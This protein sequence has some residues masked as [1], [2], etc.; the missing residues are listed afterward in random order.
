MQV[1]HKN[2]GSKTAIRCGFRLGKYDFPEHIHQFPEIVYVLDGEMEL[3]VDGKTTLMK[4]GDIALISPFQVHSFYT[5]ESVYRW[6]C[7][8]S[9]DF[10]ANFITHEELYGSG[11]SCV[12]HASAGLLSFI[13][14]H[15]LESDENF[16]E[17]NP[18][19]IRTFRAVLFAIYEEYFRKVPR[20]G[21]RKY[22]Q[23]LSSILLYIS[24]HY[25]EN[26]SLASI[27][28][29]LSYSPKYVSLC[30]A[31]IDGMN[32]MYLVNSFRADHA[33]NLLAG[34]SYRMIDIA[35]ECGYSNERSFYR[36]FHDVTGMTPGEYRKHKRTLATQETERDFY[37][38]L[39]N[40]KR[41]NQK[42]Y[43]GKIK[44]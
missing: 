44:K 15:L 8:F 19:I 35:E 31:E 27:G 36:S 22:N 25:T 18:D 23:A 41:A 4:A 39:Y 16:I 6:V 42:A 26:I 20:L 37:C 2:F 32:L 11:E 3:T 17:L 9:C 24:E 12:F 38:V 5:P 7:V 34:T 43:K 40:E 30:L 10:V 29:A 21:K 1:H 28:S 33:K 14:S 13:K